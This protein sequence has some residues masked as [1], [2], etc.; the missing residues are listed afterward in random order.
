MASRSHGLRSKTRKKLRSK[1][2]TGITPYMREFKT[3]EKVHLV[4]NPDSRKIPHPR[5]HG[6]TGKVVEKRGNSY[7]V[8][9]QRKKVLVRPEHLKKVTG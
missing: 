7:M 4:I 8:S 9:V 6:K 2:K 3:G 5:F 1:K